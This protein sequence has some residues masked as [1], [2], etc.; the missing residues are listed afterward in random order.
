MNVQRR[1]SACN[2]VKNQLDITQSATDTH[3]H[4]SWLYRCGSFTIQ[5]RFDF[6]S[7]AVRRAS[8]DQR[9]LKWRNTLAAVT[10]TYLFI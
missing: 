3:A 4:Y 6:D 10:M 7:T 5:V 1:A 2:Q 8:T 9:S